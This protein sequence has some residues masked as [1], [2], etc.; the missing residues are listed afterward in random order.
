[1]LQGVRVV[2]LATLVAV[3]TA[4]AVLADLGAEV[5]KIESKD[6]DAL[7]RQAQPGEEH[8]PLFTNCNRGGSSVRL[9]D[10]CS[11]KRHVARS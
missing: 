11:P 1:M 7:R 4:A 2:E 9:L 5:I 3:P 8:S 6:G 10:F